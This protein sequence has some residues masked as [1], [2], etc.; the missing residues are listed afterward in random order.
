MAARKPECFGSKKSRGFTL[1]IF[2]APDPV[3]GQTDIGNTDG[4]AEEISN[5]CRA[6]NQGG[7]MKNEM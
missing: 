6:A 7:G 3:S 5:P 2:V 4:L 1:A